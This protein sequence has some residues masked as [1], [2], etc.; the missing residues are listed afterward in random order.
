MYICTLYSDTHTHIHTHMCRYFK[1]VNYTYEFIYLLR[2]GEREREM[3]IKKP[4]QTKVT[5]NSVFLSPY[6]SLSLAPR[7]SSGAS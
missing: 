6:S 1:N 4:N 2:E 7:V 5:K 3:E